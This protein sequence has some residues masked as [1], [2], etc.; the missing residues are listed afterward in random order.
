MEDLSQDF[1]RDPETGVL[2]GWNVKVEQTGWQQPPEPKRDGLGQARTFG[3]Y[4]VRAA[5]GLPF[6]SGWQGEH[7]LDYR[8]AGNP[9]WD[10]PAN[11]G[12]CPL[13]AVN[14]GDMELLLG[15]EIFRIA[16]VSIPLWDFWVLRREGALAAADVM[17]RPDRRIVRALERQ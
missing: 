15:W 11:C 9:A 7:Y 16:G 17:P 2:R 1:H 4:E 8:Y 13:V 12:Y 5:R 6:P 3:H 14:A 10:V